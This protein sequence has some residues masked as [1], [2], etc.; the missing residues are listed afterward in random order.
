MCTR[1][2]HPGAP[3][4]AV[5]DN[6][7]CGFAILFDPVFEHNARS[8]A[9]HGGV[10]RIPSVHNVRPAIDSGAHIRSVRRES[11]RFPRETGR[12]LRRN[13]DI[14]DNVAMVSR[15]SRRLRGSSHRMRRRSTPCRRAVSTTP[16]VLDRLSWCFLRHM[17]AAEVRCGRPCARVRREEGQAQD[18]N[19]STI[20]KIEC[21]SC[22]LVL[23][24]PPRRFS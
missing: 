9:P 5:H 24:P 8:S 3:H 12:F 2:A 15:A 17:C 16:D 7:G 18:A 4:L 10:S 20:V 22:F 6:G 1:A 11:S 19:R 14:A 13:A 21:K 23:G